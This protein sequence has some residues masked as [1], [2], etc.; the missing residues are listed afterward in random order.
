MRACLHRT[1]WKMQK[2]YY[3]Q[4]ENRA[5]VISYLSFRTIWLWQNTRRRAGEDPKPV[6]S[7]DW[8]DF[9][10]WLCSSDHWWYSNEMSISGESLEA[11]QRWWQLTAAPSAKG[12]MVLDTLLG[13][14]FCGKC[15]YVVKNKIAIKHSMSNGSLISWL[16]NPTTTP[17]AENNQ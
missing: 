10:N 2:S 3:Y 13:E 12:P 4:L 8:I 11:S 6:Y 14:L 7:V 17:S 15:G 16:A 9:V 1:A 5:P